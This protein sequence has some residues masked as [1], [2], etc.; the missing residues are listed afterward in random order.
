MAK[1]KNI[2]LYVG[3]SQAAKTGYKESCITAKIQIIFQTICAGTKVGIFCSNEEVNEIVSGL[4]N[5][6]IRRCTS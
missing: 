1:E 6:T 2:A 3:G 4:T 5:P